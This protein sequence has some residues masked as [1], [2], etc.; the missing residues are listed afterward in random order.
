MKLADVTTIHKKDEATLM[1]NY[2]PIRL[3]PI[4]Y[5]QILLYIDKFISPYMFEYRK[6]HSTEQWSHC[7]VRSLEKVLDHKGKAGAMLTDLSKAFHC[8]NHSLLLAK[9]DA[10]GP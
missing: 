8:L 6:G 9:M 3:I 2:R 1:K 7:Y 5:N 4:V 10:Y